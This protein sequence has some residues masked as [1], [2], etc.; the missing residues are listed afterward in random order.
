MPHS[1]NYYIQ[2]SDEFS[3]AIDQ[4]GRQALLELANDCL[5]KALNY[6]P[7]AMPEVPIFIGEDMH[8]VQHS[9]LIA[10]AHGLLSKAV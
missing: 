7:V 10:I 9:N 6:C 1:I 5:Y 4:L 3:T 2:L 8:N